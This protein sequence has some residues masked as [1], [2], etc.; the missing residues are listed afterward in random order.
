MVLLTTIEE[1]QRQSAL[2]LEARP[3]TVRKSGPPALMVAKS[4]LTIDLVTDN[5]EVQD[6]KSGVA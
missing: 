5:D 1:W 3:T 6:P 4:E 2:L